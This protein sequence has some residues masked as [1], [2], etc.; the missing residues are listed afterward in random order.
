MRRAVVL[1]ALA[2][3]PAALAQAPAPPAPTPAPVP[4]PVNPC[5][6]AAQ[7]LKCPDLTMPAPSDL[8]LRR[9]GS[10]R[11]QLLQATNR[12]VNVGDGPMEV[13]GRRTGSRVMGEVTQVI[14][15]TG[16]TRRRFESSGRL[17]FT[18]IPGQYGYWKYENAAY[19]EL[20]ELDRSGARVR[21]AELGPKQNYCLRDY[22]K[23]RAYAVRLG[24]GACKQNPRLNSVKLGT[25]RGWSDTYFYGYAGSNHIDV[26]GLR[27]C[28]AFD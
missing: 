2:A 3:A 25:S 27:G 17:R 5:D 12:L 6:D 11:R 10:G 9:S 4:V 18:F 22:E 13:R 8:H 14:D 26:T 24:Y 7:R 28:Y 21:R 16:S 15:T 23:V 20:W 19:F 1:A